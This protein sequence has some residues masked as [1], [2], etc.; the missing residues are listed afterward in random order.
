MNYVEI[1]KKELRIA[2]LINKFRG[3]Q[4]SSGDTNGKSKRSNYS[5]KPERR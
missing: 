2:E 4:R 3:N 5:G 1:L